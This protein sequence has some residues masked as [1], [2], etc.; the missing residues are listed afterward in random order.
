MGDSAVTAGACTLAIGAQIDMRHGGMG[1][2]AAGNEG[3][4]RGLQPSHF[5]HVTMK[6]QQTKEPMG[7]GRANKREKSNSSTPRAASP[8]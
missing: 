4:Q 2:G 5:V 3:K 1:L 7:D 6:W 8:N